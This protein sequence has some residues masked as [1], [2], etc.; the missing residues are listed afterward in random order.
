MRKG[1]LWGSGT[2]LDQTSFGSEHSDLHFSKAPLFPTGMRP[3]GDQQDTKTD[4]ADGQTAHPVK[5]LG[6]P[7][8]PGLVPMKS[9][10]PTRQ[11]RW[12]R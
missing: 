10:R 9:C 5:T 1:R 11:Q 12:P 7:P 6:A 8:W 2:K 3:L 4:A